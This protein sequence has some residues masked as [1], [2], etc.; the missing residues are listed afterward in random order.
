LT[1]LEFSGCQPQHIRALKV[2][3]EQYLDHRYCLDNGME[4][5]SCKGLSF[6]AWLGRECVAVGGVTHLFDAHGV[7]WCMMGEA[8]APHFATLTRFSRQLFNEQPYRR[9]SATVLC[10]FENGHRWARAL[11]FA[12]ECE[13][14][15]G[16][17]H[18]GRDCALYRRIRTN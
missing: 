18:A 6:S 12:L 14:M 4:E 7:A 10:D 16:Y 3:P 15:V 2:Q 11:R 8:V 5:A 13:R 9:L 17:D 1:V